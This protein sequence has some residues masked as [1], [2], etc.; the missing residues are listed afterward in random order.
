MPSVL[1]VTGSLKDSSP[2][3]VNADTHPYFTTDFSHSFDPHLRLQESV[4]FPVLVHY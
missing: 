3:P 2:R 1:R 4:Y